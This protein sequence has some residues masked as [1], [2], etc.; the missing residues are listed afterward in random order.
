MVHAWDIDGW[1][2]NPIMGWGSPSMCFSVA[3]VT[4]ETVLSKYCLYNNWFCPLGYS[5]IHLSHDSKSERYQIIIERGFMIMCCL[6]Q[7]Y[8]F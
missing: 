2:F 8:M 6:P 3:E 5:C 4:L 7:L 1:L